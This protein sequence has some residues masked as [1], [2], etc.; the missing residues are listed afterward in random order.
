M[1]NEIEWFAEITPE[2]HKCCGGKG[3]MLARMLQAGY[4]VPDGFIVFPQAFQG[5]KLKESAWQEM[6][7]YLEKLRKNYSNV[8]FAVRSSALSEDSAL[9]SFAGEFESVLEVQTNDDVLKALHVVHHSQYSERVRAYS[10]VQGFEEAHEMAIVVQIMVPSKIS[11]VLFTADP[12]SGNRSVMSGNFVFGLGEQLVSGEGNAC[13]FSLFKPS[14]RYEGPQELL[15]YFK[16]LYRQASRLEKEMGEPQDIEWAI[17]NGKLFFL[18]AR[19]ITTL[20]PGNMDTFEWNDSLTGDFLWTNTNV[21]E[22]ISD[23]VTPLSWSIIRALDEEHN[24]IPGYYLMSGNIC[25]RVYSNIS[26]SLSVFSAFGWNKKSL[27]KKNE[28][29]IWGNTR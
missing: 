7:R 17:A 25:G 15:P 13:A 9:A 11:G 4:P 3:G 26:V 2:L 19:P 5:E 16:K 27:L 28:Q 18:Q 21:G 29:C 8:S 22:S 1:G 12:I 14:G 6:I 23:V 24:V 10:V 20:S